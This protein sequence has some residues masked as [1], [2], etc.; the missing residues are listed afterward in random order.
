M[1]LLGELL[2]EPS[3]VEAEKGNVP[4]RI[5]RVDPTQSRAISVRE[6]QIHSLVQQLF[7][8]RESAPVRRVGFTPVE[9]S[10]PTASL[11]LDVAKA[12]V[13]ESNHEVVL[14]D[15]CVGEVP[16]SSRLQIPAPTGVQVPWTITPRLWLAPW[17]SWCP[18]HKP[19]TDQNIER[20][21]EI[22]AEFDFSIVHC[23]PVCWLTARVGHVCDGLVLVL[24]ANRTRRLAA[25]QVKQQ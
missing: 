16:L 2:R 1:T 21:R 10:P 9:A 15:A 25:A 12:L 24:T 13:D 4:A 8:P 18:E 14:I 22:A 7:F 23:P 17:E 6:E 11:C 5:E 20:L 3:T 19:A